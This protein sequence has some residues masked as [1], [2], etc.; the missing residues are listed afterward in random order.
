MP[1]DQEQLRQVW[2][3]FATGVTVITTLDAQ[4][5]V[6]G[7]TANALCSVSLDPPLAL[8]LVAQERATHTLVA[9]RRSFG[10]NILAEHQREA[11][12]YYAQ[13]LKDG[14]LPDGVRFRFTPQGTAV[15]EGCLGYLDCQVVAEHKAGDHTLFIA[16][17]LEAGASQ[18]QPLVYYR[19]SYGKWE[20]G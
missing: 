2:S 8:L 5:R 13:G 10:I 15:L 1:A 6:H 3:R 9:R 16:E 20:G 14:P 4:D 11:A 7:M 18:G 12:V 17:V 19:S